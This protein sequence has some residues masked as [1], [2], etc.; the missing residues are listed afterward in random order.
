MVFGGHGYITSVIQCRIKFK[1]CLLMHLIY[2][3]WAPQ[4]AWWTVC[5]R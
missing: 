4:Y 3:G 5:S 2:T 1:L